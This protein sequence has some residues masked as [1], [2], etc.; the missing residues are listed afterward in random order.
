MSEHAL[1]PVYRYGDAL[2]SPE[3][4][5]EH[6]LDLLRAELDACRA[7]IALLRSHL[8]TIAEEHAIP[9]GPPTPPMCRICGE[10]WPCV[11]RLEADAALGAGD[12]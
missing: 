4:H 5:P 3:L 11:T 12:G 2:A 10:R 8:R 6:D 9:D 1:P 7:K